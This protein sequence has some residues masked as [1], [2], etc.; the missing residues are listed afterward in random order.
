MQVMLY[1]KE[2]AAEVEWL[3]ETEGDCCHSYRSICEALQAYDRTSVMAAING[4]VAEGT[5]KQVPGRGFVLVGDA[6]AE[7]GVGGRGISGEPEGDERPAN[8]AVREEAGDAVGEV[9]EATGQADDVPTI[10]PAIASLMASS[11][12]TAVAPTMVAVAEMPSAALRAEPVVAAPVAV[13]SAAG[14]SS[15]VAAVPAATDLAPATSAATASDA[16]SAPAPYPQAAVIAGASCSQAVADSPRNKGCILATS[17]IE[18]LD[19]SPAAAE[20]AAKAGVATVAGLIEC[21]GSGKLDPVFN[22]VAKRLAELAGTPC[23]NPGKQSLGY[24]HQLAQ[25]P[26]FY[27]DW[28]GVLCSEATPEELAEHPVDVEKYRRAVAGMGGVGEVSHGAFYRQYDDA[29]FEISM[30][31]ATIA[32][33]RYKTEGDNRRFYLYAMPLLDY[34]CRAGECEGRNEMHDYVEELLSSASQTVNACYA[35]LRDQLLDG[36]KSSISVPEGECWSAAA[37]RIAEEGQFTYENKRLSRR[38]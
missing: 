34:A 1:D 24:L 17:P 12:A 26:I 27:F 31:L 14:A 36:T 9:V 4:L 21:L 6:E 22:L 28:L 19:L 18:V 32:S 23:V 8:G 5:I 16:V 35:Y 29:A 3:I 30:A 37:A 10:A 7:A 38:S 11:I 13:S 20:Y 33:R 25:S 15:A 2:I